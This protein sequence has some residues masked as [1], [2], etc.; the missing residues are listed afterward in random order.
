LFIDV[1][2]VGFEKV[3]QLLLPTHHAYLPS[4]SLKLM[5]NKSIINYILPEEGL[6]LFIWT[7]SIIPQILVELGGVEPQGIK[8]TYVLA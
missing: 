3:L 8:S 5:L 7:Y 2:E 1:K 4:Y 6:E